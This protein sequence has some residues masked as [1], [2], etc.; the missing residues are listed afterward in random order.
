VFFNADLRG[1]MPI[2]DIPEHNM[3]ITFET[4]QF[5][6]HE[7]STIITAVNH[8][9]DIVLLKEFNGE[10]KVINTIMAIADNTNLH[11]FFPLFLIL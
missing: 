7:G 8:G 4:G 10:M 5:S 6:N 9:I 3:D 11:D 1:E 2:I